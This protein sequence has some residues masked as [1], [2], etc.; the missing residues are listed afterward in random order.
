V[1]NK[2]SCLGPMLVLLGGMSLSGCANQKVTSAWQDNAPRNQSFRR[3]LVVGVSPD[4]DGRC[5]FEHALAAR[6]KSAST[7]AIASCDAVTQKEPLT[8]ES[9]DRAIVA[10]QADGVVA[11]FLVSRKWEVEEGGTYDTRGGGYYKPTDTG[12]A[13][14]GAY[15]VPVVYGEFRTESSIMTLKGKVEVTTKVYETRG[16]SL[17]Y[18][19]DTAAWDLESTD[20]GRATIATSIA[21]RLYRDALIR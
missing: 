8:R 4:V 10:Q 1:H 20:V 17:I 15:G 14:Y 3:V 9:I 6:I 7:T 12:Y 21:D 13:N 18:T 16:A 19:V 2:V 5:E 11:T